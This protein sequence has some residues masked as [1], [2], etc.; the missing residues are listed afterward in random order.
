MVADMPEVENEQ[1][2]PITVTVKRACELSGLGLTTLWSLI[3]S[4]RLKTR[5][6]E[7]I[8]RTLVTYSSLKELLTPSATENVALPPARR[9]RG[10]PRKRRTP[11][12]RG[13]RPPSNSGD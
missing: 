7:G 3:K 6:V 13:R 5:R 11:P 2:D 10:R 4:G 9:A 8:D 1:R 12:L